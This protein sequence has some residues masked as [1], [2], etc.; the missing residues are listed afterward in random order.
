MKRLVFLVCL[1]KGAV[2]FAGSDNGNRQTLELYLGNHPFLDICERITFVWIPLDDGFWVSETELT[3]G[4]VA[5][6]CGEDV[7]SGWTLG[8]QYDVGSVG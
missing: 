8:G 2:A 6:I 4:Q 1:L 3:R 7:F 5:Q